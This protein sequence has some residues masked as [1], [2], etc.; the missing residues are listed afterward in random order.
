VKLNAL[1]KFLWS[2]VAEVGEEKAKGLI[3]DLVRELNEEVQ[4]LMDDEMDELL[5]DVPDELLGVVGNVLFVLADGPLADKVQ[6]LVDKAWAE[7]E[8]INPGDA[9]TAPP[10]VDFGGGADEDLE[11]DPDDVT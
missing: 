4:Q 9:P 1:T 5:K 6:K 2:L 10:E 8:K 11:D 3:A 7:A